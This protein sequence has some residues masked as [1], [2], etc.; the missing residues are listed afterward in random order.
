MPPFVGTAYALGVSGKQKKVQVTSKKMKDKFTLKFELLKQ[1]LDNVQSSIRT[2][3]N[4][5]MDV[6]K[7]A[8]TVF[9]AI[10]IFSF[11]NK[12]S[13][14]FTIGVISIFLF[15]LIESIF[16]SIQGIFIQR[17]NEI[18]SFLKSDAFEKAIEKE[19]FGEFI[20]PDTGRKFAVRYLDKWKDILRKGIMLHTSMLYFTMLVI[21]IMI[22]LFIRMN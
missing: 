15:W 14:G 13:F 1:E 12:I 7:W 6:K 21:L 20:I 9:T 10:V 22:K 16:K 4:L 18:E 5:V 3:D 11:E 8:I 19:N 2:Y 17:S